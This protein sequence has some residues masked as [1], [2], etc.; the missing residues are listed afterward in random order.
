[1]V[2]D[3]LIRMV[4]IS[5]F[6]LFAYCAPGNEFVFGAWTNV[7]R[8]E[9]DFDLHSTGSSD[10]NKTSIQWEQT[11]RTTSTEV[12]I[13][14]AC[15]NVTIVTD[16]H[17][18]CSSILIFVLQIALVSFRSVNWKHRDTK[19]MNYSTSNNSTTASTSFLDLY[20]APAVT[21]IILS[22]PTNVYVLWK[23]V[24]GGERLVASDFFA[25][26][27]V[28]VWDPLLPVPK[29]EPSGLIRPGT[30]YIVCY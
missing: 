3:G 23:I 4:V 24:T 16:H 9:R 29:L 18:F 5:D 13:F 12:W 27:T 14:L 8:W 10:S 22:L 25:P 28:C 11:E 15:A 19:E 7:I 20:L 17:A 1:M 6:P 2:N 21:N 30:C 26:Q